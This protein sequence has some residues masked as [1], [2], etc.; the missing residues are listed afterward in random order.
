MRSVSEDQ[1]GMDVDAL[2]NAL[3]TFCSSQS[4]E[5]LPNRPTKSQDSWRKTYKHVIY[6]VPSFSNPSGK[7]MSL[8]RREELIRVAREYDA[9]IICDDVY[10]MLCWA[11]GP[12]SESTRVQDSLNRLV[13]IECT[14]DDGP[15]DRFGN[16]VS[17]G[18]FSKLIGPGCRVGW[19]QGTKAFICGLS[20]AGQTRSGGAPSQLTS[21]MVNKFFDGDF[22]QNY[23]AKGLVPKCVNRY[24]VMVSAI[25]RCLGP[26]GVAYN[27]DAQFS[28]IAGGYYIWL[29]LPGSLRAADVCEKALEAQNL[30][31]GCGDLFELPRSTSK[32]DG[33]QRLRLCF[34]YED[35]DL[36]VAGVER[37]A[38]VIKGMMLIN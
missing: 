5:V 1:E 33:H 37:L 9:L 15:I 16:V 34:M 7:T 32:G 24:S 26:F 38:I 21:T 11:L 35:E 19:A 22:L 10:D 23:I 18:S 2:R 4:T 6:C 29:K 30:I 28:N 12:M 13:D 31:L 8:Q 27:P 14:L 25:E 36:L 3:E 17:N 20:Q